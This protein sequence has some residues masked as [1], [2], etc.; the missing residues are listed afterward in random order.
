MMK[1][2]AANMTSPHFPLNVDASG[3]GAPPS[4]NEASTRRRVGAPVGGCLVTPF[5]PFVLLKPGVGQ[6]LF[7]AH[8]LGGNAVEVTKLGQR[9]DSP[10]SV[11]A[12]QAKGVDGT[13]EPLDKVEDMVAYYLAHLR[14]LQ[15]HGPYYLAGYSFGGILAME[16]ARRLMSAGETVGLLAFIDSFAHPRT[17]TKTARQIIRLKRR[18]VPLNSVIAAFRTKPLSEACMF[19]AARLTARMTGGAGALPRAYFPKDDADPTSRKVHS[20]ALTALINYW[21]L[22]Y[23]GRVEFFRPKTSIFRVAPKRVWGR[24]LGGLTLHAVRGD[25]D[26][27]VREHAP[28]LAVALSTALR[29][30]AEVA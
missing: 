17:F 21:P 19:V 11:Y 25:H 14:S 4:S 29:R 7:I 3:L 26:S 6:P 5:S 9:I 24:L 2:R 8:G 22:S 18:I 16:M 30:A 12:I 27:M 15:P 10:H 13:E 1:L 28:Y 23:P 20:A